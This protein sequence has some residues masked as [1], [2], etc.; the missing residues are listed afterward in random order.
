MVAEKA[1]TEKKV[2]EIKRNAEA[3][4]SEAASLK[5]ELDRSTAVAEQAAKERDEM[6]NKLVQ[7]QEN[8]EKYVAD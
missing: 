5:E 8:W 4:V 1:E 3:A 6:Q 2:E 7:L